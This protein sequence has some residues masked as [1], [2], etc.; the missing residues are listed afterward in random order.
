MRFWK[1]LRTQK[2]AV[3][4]FKQMEKYPG[5]KQAF[6]FFLGIISPYT[7]SL[8]PHVLECDYDGCKIQLNERFALQNPYGRSLNLSISL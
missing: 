1:K 6:S 7:G 5:G 3:K 2:D 8:R 4:I